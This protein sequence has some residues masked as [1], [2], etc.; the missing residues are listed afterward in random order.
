MRGIQSDDSDPDVISHGCDQVIA[1][2]S[3][4]L[5]INPNSP[6]VHQSKSFYRGQTRMVEWDRGSGMSRRSH[7]KTDGPRPACSCAGIEP[8]MPE[9]PPISVE[10]RPF[11]D[12]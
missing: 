10:T 3:P 9:K 6:P 5:K 4:K 1:G 2:R 7:T 8:R 12:S 11:Y